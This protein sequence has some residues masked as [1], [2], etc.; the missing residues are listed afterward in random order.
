MSEDVGAGYLARVE[1]STLGIR[2]GP[3]VLFL[4]LTRDLPPEGRR[5]DMFIELTPGQAVSLLQHVQECIGIALA[6]SD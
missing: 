2:P 4:R 1:A 3:G 6:T 5:T